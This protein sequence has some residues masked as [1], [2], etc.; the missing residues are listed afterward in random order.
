MGVFNGKHRRQW[1]GLVGFCTLA[2]NL[3]IIMSWGDPRSV[4]RWFLE[5]SHHAAPST[6]SGSVLLH[7]SFAEHSGLNGRADGEHLVRNLRRVVSNSRHC[8]RGIFITL[9]PAFIKG[10]KSAER[11]HS[12]KSGQRL[13]E[14][15]KKEL[16][17]A[18]EI[19]GRFCATFGLPPPEVAFEVSREPPPLPACRH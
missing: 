14:A 3:L 17:H 6:W 12:S 11:L 13:L 10:T 9:D 7:M 19:T 16:F 5:D 8:F 18:R 4:A 2:A 1:L 15:L